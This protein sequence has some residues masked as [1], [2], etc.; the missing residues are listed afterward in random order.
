MLLWVAPILFVALMLA[1]VAGYGLSKRLAKRTSGQPTAWSP[2]LGGA[3]GLLGLLIAF[4]LAMATERY[5][6][7]R[8]LVVSEANALSTTYLRDSA[9]VGGSGAR[10]DALIVRYG[11]E[12]LAFFD[13]GDDKAR[14]D[15]VTRRTGALKDEIW[16]E[17]VAAVLQ[18]RQTAVDAMV[19]A[20]TGE[21]FN[22]AASRMAARQLR[23]PLDVL[24]LLTFIAIGTSA[25]CGYTLGLSG[26]RHMIATA[27]LLAMISVS[28]AMIIDMDTPTLGLIQVPQWPM[29]AAVAD[30]K[31]H[32]LRRQAFVP[33]VPAE[34]AADPDAP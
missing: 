20:S 26:D 30:L 13:A 9:Y 21:M 2:L 28:V 11:A 16:K 19:L 12:R 25:L 8:E 5:E 17:T 32:E 15:E 4:T 33:D 34:A 31:A 22:L 6:T 29:N 14:L 18:P 27:A 3:I 1:N 23:V 10:L 7:R 24:W